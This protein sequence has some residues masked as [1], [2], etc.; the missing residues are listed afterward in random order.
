MAPVRGSTGSPVD[1]LHE[2]RRYC[3][4]PSTLNE[5]KTYLPAISNIYPKNDYQ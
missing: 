2:R 3:V 4:T 5:N 1:R